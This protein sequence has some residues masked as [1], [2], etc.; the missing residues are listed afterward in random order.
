MPKV[1]ILALD[2]A[3]FRA[4]DPWMRAGQLPNLERFRAQAAYGPLEST[5]P[6]IT[7]AAWTTFQTGCNPGKHGF[8]DWLRRAPNGYHLV[9]I[10]AQLLPL[11]TIWDVLSH[12]GAKVSVLGVPVNYPPRPVNGYMVSGLL[13]PAGASYTYPPA[14]QAELEQAV[15]GFNT[16]PEHWRGRFQTAQ[17]LDSLKQSLARKLNVAHALLDKEWD[18]FMVHFMETDSVQHQMWHVIDGI[19]RPRYRAKRLPGNPILE[20]FQ[21]LDRALPDL[22][23]RL[24]QGT[25]TIVLSDHGFGPLHWNVYLNNWLLKEGYLK[26]KRNA[27]T[28]MKRAAFFGL[29]FTPESLY[30]WGELTGYLGRNSQ[31][32]HA[33]IYQRM[34][35]F[36]LSH[37][38]IDWGRTRAYSFGNVGQVYLNLRGREPQGIVAQAERKALAEEIRAGLMSLRNPA[39]GELVFEAGCF[40]EQLYSGEALED[41]PELILLPNEGYMA[42]GTSEFVSK[43]IVSPACWGSGWHR[44][45]GILMANGPHVKPGQLTNARLMDMAS[46]LLYLMG[47]PVPQTLDGAVLKDLFDDAFLKEHP[48]QNGAAIDKLASQQPLPEGY[49][50]EIRRRLQS[51][52]YI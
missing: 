14:L 51:L 39:N 1:F 9:P 41:A 15:P 23:S 25:T 16:M 45:D 13:A 40:K 42:V 11:P 28:W 47:L 4:L 48:I 34:G 31:L 20:I 49:D 3:T 27:A 8:F 10:N 6:P 24:P 22:L 37:Q 36:F 44:M 18:V 32:R 43:R 17:W 30:P 12:H 7:G 50:E 21:Q 33:Q 5:I 29:G 38:H 35:R 52:G 26:L 2:G 46:T 19:E